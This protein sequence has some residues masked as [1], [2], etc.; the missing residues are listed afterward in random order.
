MSEMSERVTVVVDDDDTW[1]WIWW[2][3]A[4]MAHGFWVRSGDSGGGQVREK[5]R[6]AVVSSEIIRRS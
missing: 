4:V 1:D 2:V 3:V 6:T 5:E